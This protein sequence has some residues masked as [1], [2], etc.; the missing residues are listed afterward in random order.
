MTRDEAE[1]LW[2]EVSLRRGSGT[3]PAMAKR[4]IAAFVALGM[5]KLDPSPMNPE[6]RAGEIIS[7]YTTGADTAAILMELSEAGL[8]I[9]P[10]SPQEIEGAEK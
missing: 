9:V 7:A 3:F 6:M 8:M 4:D 1:A 5:L 10:R 2:L